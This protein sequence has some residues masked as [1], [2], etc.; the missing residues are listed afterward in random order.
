VVVDTAEEAIDL[1]GRRIRVG[2]RQRLAHILAERRV[3]FGAPADAD[4][5]EIGREELPAGHREYC[6]K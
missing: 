3:V 1:P 6:S 2:S 4:H 5:D